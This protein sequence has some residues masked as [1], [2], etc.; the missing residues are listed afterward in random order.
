MTTTTHSRALAPIQP[1]DL[2]VMIGPAGSGKSTLLSAVPAHRIVS[3]DHLRAVV[4]EPGDQ[5]A[6]SDAVRLQHQIVLARLLRGATTYVDNTSVEAPHRTELVGMADLYGRRAVA[7]L[8]DAPLQTCLDRNA[9][10][11]AER[12]VP[13]DVLRWQHD[14]ARAARE[15]LPHEGF[16]EIRHLRTA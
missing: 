4:S 9:R 16:A 1:G 10:R 14:L 7:V 6:T 2:V 13:E 5:N 11:P 12:R 15:L 8:V 3:L